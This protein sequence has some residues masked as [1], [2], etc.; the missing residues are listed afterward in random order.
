LHQGCN[1]AEAVKTVSEVYLLW[2]I[3][4]ANCINH[5]V[6]KRGNLETKFA[7]ALGFKLG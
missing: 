6:A 3:F 1:K 7:S 5:P 2:E 4:K